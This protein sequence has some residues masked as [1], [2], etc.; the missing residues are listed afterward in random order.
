[1]SWAE[2]TDQLPTEQS[3]FKLNDAGRHISRHRIGIQ[4]SGTMDYVRNYYIWMHTFCCSFFW[5]R[6][7]EIRIW[8]H[9]SRENVINYGAPQGSS[10][11]PLLFLLYMSKLPKLLPNTHRSL[12]AEDFMSLNLTSS[13]RQTSMDDLTWPS[14]YHP[15]CALWKAKEQHTQNINCHI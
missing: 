11:S 8:S 6:T 7:V 2:N 3:R 15:K 10:I 13:N 1:M 9:T 4:P 12:Y 5:D 14:S